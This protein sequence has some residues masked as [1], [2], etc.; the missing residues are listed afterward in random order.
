[1]CLG[2]SGEYSVVGNE[3]WWGRMR[4][5]LGAICTHNGYPT[6]KL[7]GLR[8]LNPRI[9][10]SLPL[11]SADSTNIARNIGMDSKWSSGRYLPPNKPARARVLRARIESWNGAGAWTGR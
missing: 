10:P 6:C 3:A 11:S 2:S 7:H 8:M 9:F 5:A 1:M 4:E